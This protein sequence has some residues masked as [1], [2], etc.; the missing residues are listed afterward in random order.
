MV[1]FKC[2]ITDLEDICSLVAMKGKSIDGHP[3]RAILDCVFNIVG[4][5]LKI[6]ALDLQRTFAVS[7]E[8]PVEILEEGQI[9]IVDIENFEKFLSRFNSSD[10]VEISTVENRVVIKRESPKKT[11]KFP[12]AAYDSIGSKDAPVL[13]K[14]S[15]KDEYPSLGDKTLFDTVITVNAEQIADIYKDGDVINQRMIPFTLT[16]QTISV[17]VKDDTLGEFET[18]V[19]PKKVDTI[20]KKE[21]STSAMYGNGFDNIF[22]SLSGEVKIYAINN[23]KTFPLIVTKTTDRYN[24]LTILAPYAQS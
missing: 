7:V 13:E 24:V 8:Y 15:W 20:S 16:G 12:L 11:A 22:S 9:P 14:I 17:S 6:G 10:E 2:K 21:L 3:Y 19:I 18:E 5:K 1:K 4:D 23:T